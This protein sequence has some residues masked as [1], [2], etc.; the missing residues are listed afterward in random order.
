MMILCMMVVIMNIAD[1]AEIV[2]VTGDVARKL[3]RRP[4]CRGYCLAVYMMAYA[5]QLYICSPK[6]L[7]TLVFMQWMAL[8]Q[9]L[10]V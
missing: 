3:H 7:V 1:T 2:D 8:N 6:D 10:A 4:G 9:D 5:K